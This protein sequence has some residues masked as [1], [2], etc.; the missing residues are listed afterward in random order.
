MKTRA[1]AL[2]SLR[3]ATVSS[4]REDRDLQHI[5]AIPKK[6]QPDKNA[7]SLPTGVDLP[8]VPRKRQSVMAAGRGRLPDLVVPKPQPARRDPV[9]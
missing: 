9:D 3:Q 8:S 2:A 6:A 7:K 1:R 5:N 4:A